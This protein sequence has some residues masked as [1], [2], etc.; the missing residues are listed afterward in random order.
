[1]N[2]SGKVVYQLSANQKLIGSYF[3]NNKIRGHRRDSNDIIPDI[4]SRRQTNP[5]QT[6]QAKYTGI[7]G[8]LV[9]ES[10]FSVMDGQTNYLY[11]PDTDP[12]SVRIIDTGT[13]KVFNA[14]RPR[15]YISRTPAISSTTCSPWARADLAASTCSR[16]AC[17]GAGCTS[18]RPIRY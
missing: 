13:T 17:S 3:W 10:N 12:A 16:P 9:F 6:T 7:R 15:K 8:S 18:R 1:M 5:V 4:A 11:Q 14:H 2:Y